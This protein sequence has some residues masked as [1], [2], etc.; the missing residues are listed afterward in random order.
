MSSSESRPITGEDRGEIE[1]LYALYCRSID[2]CD[3]EGWVDCFAPDGIYSR[4][5]DG[6]TIVSRGKDE[7]LTF[8][9]G[10]VEWRG[11]NYLHVET[12]ILLQGDAGGVKGSCTT[13]VFDTSKAGEPALSAVGVYE[14]RLESH[15]GRW[16]FVSRSVVAR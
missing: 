3:A 4:T 7:L 15:Q 10:I 1:N 5:V 14:D 9:R 16:R 13:V 11:E 8:A 6:E 12:N 2:S